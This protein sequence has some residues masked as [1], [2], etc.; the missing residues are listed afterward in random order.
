MKQTSDE[1]VGHWEKEDSWRISCQ[2]GEVGPNKQGPE[3]EGKQEIYCYGRASRVA[4][5]PTF[6]STDIVTLTS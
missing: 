1:R 5:I 6:S 4:S 2:D 3:Q